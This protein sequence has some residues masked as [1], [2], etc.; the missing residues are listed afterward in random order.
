MACNGIFCSGQLDPPNQYRR[1]VCLSEAGT[2]RQTPRLP[3]QT[4]RECFL[5]TCR[6]EIHVLL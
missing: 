6:T 1:I 2:R 4:V 5:V 3:G